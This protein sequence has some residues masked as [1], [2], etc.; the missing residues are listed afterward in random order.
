MRQ[1][2]ICLLLSTYRSYPE[3]FYENE[4]WIIKAYRILQTT[5]VLTHETQTQGFSKRPEWQRVCA[6]WL[7]RF[8]GAVI[9]LKWTS[10]PDMMEAFSFPWHQL[11]MKSFQEDFSC[12]WLLSS[13]TKEQLT[14]LF[15][16]RLDLCAKIGHLIRVL[17]KRTASEIVALGEN[18]EFSPPPPSNSLAIEELE[19]RLQQWK[20]D[21]ASLLARSASSSA[22]LFEKRLL[23]VE[24]IHTKLIFE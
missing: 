10:S 17:W 9:G 16:A 4:R 19:A 12:S 3:Q 22:P 20:L 18:P 8:T 15:V 11:T 13:G 5:G 2:Q 1:V 6:C 7:L 24:Q 21:N 23:H 14:R